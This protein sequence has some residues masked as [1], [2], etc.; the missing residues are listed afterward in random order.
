[1]PGKATCVQGVK[2]MYMEDAL[3]PKRE[4]CTKGQQL[5]AWD[6]D[7]SP[8]TVAWDSGLGTVGRVA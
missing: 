7:H 1:M 8:G 6:G 4:T 3:Y 2:L 5:V